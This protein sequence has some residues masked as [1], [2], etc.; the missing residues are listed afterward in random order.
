MLL[1]RQLEGDGTA[2][3]S[4][5][6][7]YVQR[8]AGRMPRSHISQGPG[9]SASGDEL[10][11]QPSFDI[12]IL[13]VVLFRVKNGFAAARACTGCPVNGQSRIGRLVII[14]GFENFCGHKRKVLKSIAC[15]FVSEQLLIP[16]EYTRYL[17]Q[18]LL[19]LV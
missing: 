1:Y 11:E 18:L 12:D 7:K 16:G 14:M 15:F 8:G 5:P 4:E 10:A 19:Q 17:L 9:A 13:P 6:L 3:Q 2:F